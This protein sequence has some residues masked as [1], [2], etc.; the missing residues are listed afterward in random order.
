M[1]KNFPKD[2]LAFGFFTGSNL[3]DMK[4]VCK[5][6]AKYDEQQKKPEK[7]ILKVAEVTCNSSLALAMLYP[8]YVSFNTTK[9]EEECAKVF[10]EA[11]YAPEEEVKKN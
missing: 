7:L 9:G 5:T 1:S 3:N 6:V 8:S 10:N 11:F 2:I 4:L